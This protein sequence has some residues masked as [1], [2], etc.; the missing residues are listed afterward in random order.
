MSDA[1]SLFMRVKAAQATADVQTM[2]TLF[3]D[4]A[5][6]Y[7]PYVSGTRTGPEVAE[8]MGTACGIEF[9][10]IAYSVIS[11]VVEGERAAIELDEVVTLLDGKEVPVRNCTIVESRDGKVVRWYEYLQPMKRR[12]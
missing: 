6:M 12:P 5:T 8:Y 4:D 9:A 7:E 3:A 2:R 10:A 1:T 11:A